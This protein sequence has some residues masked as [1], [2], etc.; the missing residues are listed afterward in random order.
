[1]S[2]ELLLPVEEIAV[3]HTALQSDLSLGKKIKLHSKQD[4]FPDL[5][6]IQ[7]AIIG[8]AEGRG[9]VDNIGT[10]KGLEVIRKFLYQMFPGNWHVNVADLGN[11]PTGNE[12]GDTYFLVQEIL[13]ELIEQKITPIIIGGSQDITYANYRAYDRIGKP[14]NIVSVDNRF[15]SG[16]NRKEDCRAYLAGF[17]CLPRNLTKRTQTPNVP[18]HYHKSTTICRH[19]LRHLSV[20]PENA[21]VGR[22]VSGD[23]L[24]KHKLI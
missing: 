3:A 17:T 11:I 10:G 24:P 8:V 22:S 13:G 23:Q 9:A 2:L 4:G 18:M 5:E 21:L 6:N 1:M 14:V 16:K 20:H 12:T 15:D 19:R 7:I